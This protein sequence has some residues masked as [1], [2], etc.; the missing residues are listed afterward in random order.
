MR[1]NFYSFGNEPKSNRTTTTKN[2]CSTTKE[3]EF[4]LLLK[5]Q[6]PVLGKQTKQLENTESQMKPSVKL[7]I[8][9]KYTQHLQNPSPFH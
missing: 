6:R 2:L 9:R 5:L 8:Q 3:N 7:I 4:I 1:T